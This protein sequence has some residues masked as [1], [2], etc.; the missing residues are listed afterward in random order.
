[1]SFVI[2]A[3]IQVYIIILSMFL[4][5]KAF[6]PGNHETGIDVHDGVGKFLITFFNSTSSGII[7]IAIAATYGLYFVASFLYLDPWHMFTSFPAYLLLQVSSSLFRPSPG[8]N[9]LPFVR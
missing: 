3:V 2:F 7:I 9:L 5:V 1:M 4:V 6:L 8:P